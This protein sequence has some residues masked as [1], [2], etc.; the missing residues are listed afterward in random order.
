MAE[1]TT[2]ELTVPLPRPVDRRL[3]LG[4]FPSARDALKF[5]GVAAG[6]LLVVPLVGPAAIVPFALAGFV[7]AVHRSDG[8]SL[9]E[10]VLGY[11]GYRWRRRHGAAHRPVPPGGTGAPRHVRLAGGRV[12]AVLVAGGVPVSF[13]PPDDARR[14]FEATRGWLETLGDGVYLVADTVPIPAAPFR[15]RLPPPEEPDR[16]AGVGYD[17]VVRLLLRRRRAR[18]VT[19]VLWEPADAAGQ[20]RLEDRAAASLVAL[21]TLGVVADRLTGAPLL[22]AIDRLD[23]ARSGPA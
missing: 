20:A 1:D 10:R 3:H 8:R 2:P 14:L 6:G 5:A 22:A 18:R 12:A 13:L 9:D 4:P 17:E 7:L 19:L 15:P 23:L 21:A 11:L 16:A